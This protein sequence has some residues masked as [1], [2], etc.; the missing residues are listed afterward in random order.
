MATSIEV[1]LPFEIKIAAD[2]KPGDQLTIGGKFDYL[3]CADICIPEGVDAF[4]HAA[5]CATALATDDDGQRDHR[6]DA[7]AAFPSR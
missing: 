6:R 2:A 5:G 3:I 7:A 4:D 1:V